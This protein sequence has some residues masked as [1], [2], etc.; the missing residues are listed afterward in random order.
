MTTASCWQV[1]IDA[2][3]AV[4]PAVADALA[5]HVD[6]VSV[7]GDPD[8][9]AIRILAHTAE[10]P[11]TSQLAAA[12][13]AVAP[14]L[15]IAVTDLGTRDWLAENRASFA[16]IAVGRFFVH[17]THHDGPV[18]TGATALAIDA[19]AAFG[20]GAHGSTQGCLAAL[21]RLAKQGP[22]RRRAPVLDVGCG[23]A[24]L[25]LA[26]ATLTRRLAVASDI[27]PAAV[28][29]ART[30]AGLN[31]LA[32]WLTTVEAAGLDHPTIAARGPYGLIFANI[33]ARPLA[34]LAPAIAGR[35]RPGG[36]VVLSGLLI[37]QER[38]VLSRY[39]DRGLALRRRIDVGPW[40]TLV[41]RAPT[42]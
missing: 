22:L 25:A 8:D 10:R 17:P 12:V 36:H 3:T 34:D 2:P 37:E 13:N 41:L 30:N 9:A 18:P 23:T 28:A 35:L 14:N 33:L 4:A 19:A 38:Q 11:D 42:P 32:P 5:P 39:L 21:D 24:V 20:T 26:A 27:D 15:D 29:V 1:A 6:A 7:F 40:R 16:P 31:R